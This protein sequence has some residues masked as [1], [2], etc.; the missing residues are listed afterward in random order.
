M[1][2][3]GAAILT[4]ALALAGPLLLGG[5]S[6]DGDADTPILSDFMDKFSPPTPGEAARD[7]FNVYDADKRRN[8][9]NLLAASHFGGEAPYVRTY[10]LQIDDPDP[11]VRAACVKALGMH[12]QVED[13]KL[14][15]PLLA[16]DSAF[17]RWEAAKALQRIHNPIAIDPLRRTLGGDEDPDVRMACADALGQYPTPA[18]FDVLVGALIDPNF[19]VALAARRSLQTITGEDLGGEPSDWMAWAA[20]HRGSMFE[21]HQP[22]VYYPYAKPPGFFKK[23][24]PWTEQA[25]QAPPRAPVGMEPTAATPDHPD[26]G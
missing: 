21:D 10:R 16:D 22:Y 19:G 15:A 2:H 25:P 4:F 17:V 12:G 20:E 23:M 5:C 6:L 13:V 8:A 11:S 3:R 7:A 24:L 1:R 26:E 18:V 9:L 14:I